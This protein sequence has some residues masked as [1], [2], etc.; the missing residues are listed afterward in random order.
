ML[1]KFVMF[2]VGV[3]VE[4]ES[5][6]RRGR[7]RERERDKGNAD[8]PGS[9]SNEK[10]HFSHISSVFANAQPGDFPAIRDR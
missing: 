8:M 10:L 9:G 4:Q 3:A 2:P 5:C 7:V 1:N 6:G